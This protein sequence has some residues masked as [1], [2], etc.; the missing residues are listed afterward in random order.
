MRLAL[1]PLHLPGAKAIWTDF[2]HSASLRSLRTR[3]EALG[4]IDQL[5]L[6]EDRDGSDDGMSHLSTLLTLLPTL[7]RSRAKEPQIV[8]CYRDG[9]AARSLRTFLAGIATQLRRD[10]LSVR[11]LQPE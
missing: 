1:A 7:R 9:P 11:W 2:H 8:L 4:G 5:I 10:G 3:V 6:A